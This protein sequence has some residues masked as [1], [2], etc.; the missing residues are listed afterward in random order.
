MTSRLVTYR[1]S[2]DLPKGHSFGGSRRLRDVVEHGPISTPAVLL[3]GSA[4]DSR[5]QRPEEQPFADANQFCLPPLA[6]SRVLL[7]ALLGP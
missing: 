6:A 7:V 3:S 2:G 4:L 1:R 5:D